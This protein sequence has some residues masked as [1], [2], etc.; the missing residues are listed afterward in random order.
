MA[1]SPFTYGG[2]DAF[3][4][5]IEKLK[6]PLT[7]EKVKERINEIAHGSKV[8][9]PTELMGELV[10]E[11]MEEENLEDGEAAQAFALNFL[12]LWNEAVAT[13]PEGEA[14]N[15][16]KTEVQ[17]KIEVEA[18]EARKPYVAPAQPGRNDPCHCGSGKKFKKCHGA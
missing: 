15:A 3:R 13:R 16:W 4:E 7:V 6:L 1:K 10:G 14:T 11:K 18:K 17:A 2:D 12:S 9:S 5:Q 8:V